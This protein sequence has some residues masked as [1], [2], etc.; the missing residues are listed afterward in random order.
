VPGFEPDD[1]VRVEEQDGKAR[2]PER[3]GDGVERG[4]IDVLEG[5]GRAV[6]LVR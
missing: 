4:T 6:V 3:H 1:P 2:R 5:V